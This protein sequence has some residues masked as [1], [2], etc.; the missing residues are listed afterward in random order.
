MHGGFVV[1][2]DLAGLLEDET[3]GDQLV[4]SGMFGVTQRVRER[5]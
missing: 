1:S 5:I 2:L 3:R 4:R